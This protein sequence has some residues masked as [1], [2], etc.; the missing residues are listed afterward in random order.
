MNGGTLSSQLESIVG[1]AHLADPAPYAVHGRAPL[2]VASPG[3]VEELA[4]CVAVCHTARV[5]VLPWGG[6]T[7]Q[8]WGRPLTAERF[9]VLRTARLDRV[10]IYEPDDLTISV[11]AGMT[12]QALTDELA[13]NG[14]M[15][16]LDA[17]WPSR[18]TIGGVL[19]TAV[20]GPRRLLYGTARDLLI[21]IRVIEATGRVSKAGGM[22]VKN[23]SGFDLMKLYLGSLGTLAIIASANFKLVPR[24]RA[25][26]T[27]ECRF[28][29]PEG[30]LRL[31]E[32]I[33]ASQLAPAGLQYVEGWLDAPATLLVRVEG[34]PAA[35]ERHARDLRALAGEAGAL[36]VTLNDAPVE[37]Q[38]WA[39]LSQ[40]AHPLDPAPGLLALRLGCLPGSLATAL[41]DART[42]AARYA[43]ALRVLAY[44]LSGVAYL[45]AEAA[46]GDAERLRGWHGELLARWP[47]LTITSAAPGLAA[48]LPVWGA[49][50][51]NLELMRRIKAEFDPE[52]V[53]NPGRFVV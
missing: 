41:A 2:L 36:D 34:L 12:L 47:H 23:V 52:N 17:P 45:R 30:A 3:S 19:A 50:P 35:V 38:Q 14:Q 49:P 42:L 16:P 32:S 4:A 46:D 44:A 13:R 31:A 6:G 39:A 9:V 43:V 27:L 28:A 24:P 33:A 22:V 51:A 7:K 48:E 5:A 15:L 25:A 10:L 20:D 29:G 26:A 1:T 40:Q 37:Q 21:G 18:S 53:L 8:G 11:E